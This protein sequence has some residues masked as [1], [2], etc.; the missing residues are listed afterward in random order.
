MNVQIVYVASAKLY[1]ALTDG[2]LTGI[3]KDTDTTID[4][5]TIRVECLD[6]TTARTNV[7]IA[8]PDDW[9]DKSKLNLDAA[10]ITTFASWLLSTM[11]EASSK[12]F[13]NAMFGY[14]PG[15]AYFK[16][17][18]T[19]AGQIVCAPGLKR[20]PYG[21]ELYYIAKALEADPTG[22]AELA[23]AYAMTGAA[24]SRTEANASKS[25]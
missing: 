15:S 16:E 25:Q 21:E 1:V 18:L 19:A 13:G 10:D 22:F 8:K 3:V 23:A 24:N 17:V 20:P 5:C 7:H 14:F 4:P 6:V 12:A 2:R 11:P 9:T